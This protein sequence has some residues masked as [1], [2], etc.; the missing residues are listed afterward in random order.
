MEELKLQT[1]WRIVMQ[2]RVWQVSVLG[3]LVL[4]GLAGWACRRA[5]V[6]RATES[7]SVTLLRDDLQRIQIEDE[8]ELPFRIVVRGRD[9]VTVIGFSRD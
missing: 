4:T 5:T 8:Q 7:I 3:V 9:A 6:L 2:S 1:G